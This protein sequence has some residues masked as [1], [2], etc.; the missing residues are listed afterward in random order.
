VVCSSQESIL[1]QYALSDRMAEAHAMVSL[2]EQGWANK[3]R[4]RAPLLVRR[5]RCGGT[6]AASRKAAWRRWGHSDGY[7]PGRGRLAATRARLVQRLKARGVGQREIARRIGVSEKAIRKLLRRWA[8][9]RPLLF[10]ASCPWRR[11]QL[12]TQTCPLFAPP[13]KARGSARTAIRGIG[14]PTDCWRV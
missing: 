14:A 7:P 6:S 12:R 3:P 9:K 5:A 8:G 13:R 2:V 10:R 4:S 1:A 11:R